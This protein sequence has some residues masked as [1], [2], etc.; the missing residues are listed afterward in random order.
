MTLSFSGLAAVIAVGLALALPGRA[1]ADN[2]VVYAATLTSLGGAAG[3]AAIGT[4]MP[5]TPLTVSGRKN[6]FLK[7]TI[8]GWSPAGGDRYLFRAVGQRIN[9]VVL[10]DNGLKYRKGGAKKED[11]YGSNWQDAT[12]TGWI[13]KKDTTPDLNGIWKK[14]GDIYFSHCTRCHSLH[15]PREF[16]ANQWPPTLKVMTKRAGLNRDEAAL[17]TMLLQVHAKDQSVND[18]F[19]QAAATA[20]GTQQ[21]AKTPEIKDT[22]EMAAKGAEL[23]KQDNCSAC[24]GDDAK[25]PIMPDYPRLAGQSAGYL[26]KQLTDFKSGKRTNDPNQAM[27]G[28]VGALSEDDARAIAYWLSTL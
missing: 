1:A 2:P 10:T 14:A 19:A 26:L 22:P 3:G 17:V 27:R 13:A 7:V 12:V 16:T 23:F 18:A 24:H 20:K 5:S 6:G 28:A 21:T 11:D 4:V 8:R 25:T 15:R 9:E